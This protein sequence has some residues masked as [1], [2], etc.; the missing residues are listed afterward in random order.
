MDHHQVKTQKDM[1]PDECD[2]AMS[3]SAERISDIIGNFADGFS[4]KNDSSSAAF[5]RAVNWKRR[6]TDELPPVT[7]GRQW[8]ANFAVAKLEALCGGAE[9]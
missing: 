9:A 6:Q 8:Q 4:T 3:V 7:T 2:D 5:V 1:K